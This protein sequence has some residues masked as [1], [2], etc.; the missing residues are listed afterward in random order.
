MGNVRHLRGLRRGVSARPTAAEP[1]DGFEE[2]N[3]KL[4]AILVGVIL[5]WMVVA[6]IGVLTL[7]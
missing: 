3:R 5:F 7:N 1:A 4:G 6:I 2:R